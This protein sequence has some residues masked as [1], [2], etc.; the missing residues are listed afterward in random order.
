MK[1]CKYCG[2]EIFYLK[3]RFVGNCNY[4]IGINAAADKEVERKCMNVETHDEVEY[5]NKSKFYWCSK[6]GK[7]GER[8]EV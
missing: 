8:I 7:R 1:P 2:S 5:T 4:H 3:Q 6:C